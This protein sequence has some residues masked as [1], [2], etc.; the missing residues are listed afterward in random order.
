MGQASRPINYVEVYDRIRS[1]FHSW[2]NLGDK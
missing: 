2:F 1:D